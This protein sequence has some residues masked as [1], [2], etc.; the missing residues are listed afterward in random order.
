MNKLTFSEL[1]EQV[2]GAT[3]FSKQI[4]HDF[5]K[6]LSETIEAGLIRDGHVRLKGLGSFQLRQVAQRRGINP[7]TGEPIIIPGHNK[8]VFHPSIDIKNQLNENLARIVPQLPKA[9]EKPIKEMSGTRSL[10]DFW[11]T[12]K[13]IQYSSGAAALA[14]VILI[15]SLWFGG[16]DKI[17]QDTASTAV[18][19]PVDVPEPAEITATLE[20]QPEQQLVVVPATQA[21]VITSI[22]PPPVNTVDEDPI[23][24]H[25]IKSGDN[26]WVLAKEYYG[27]PYLWPLIYE[28]NKDIIANPDMLLPGTNVHIP[29][30]VG[31]V[32]ELEKSDIYWLARANALVYQV[33][34][35]SNTPG[36]QDF[37]KVA[38]KLDPGIAE[39]LGINKIPS[40]I[41]VTQARE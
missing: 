7:R 28:H 10:R 26:L 33:Y 36:A 34:S 23:I 5:L 18:V 32:K 2:A 29:T 35:Q 30:L 4:S 6:D 31:S 39:K 3:G 19:A 25:A 22:E 27:D 38:L 1:V 21:D 9:T 16:G 14:L 12:N 24:T 37:L 40:D 41:L 11:R 20:P 15:G 17:E 13:I 8:I